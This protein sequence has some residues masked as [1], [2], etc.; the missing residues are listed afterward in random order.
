M[1]CPKCRTKLDT[2]IVHSTKTLH[3]VSEFDGKRHRKIKP[4]ILSREIRKI[5]NIEEAKETTRYCCPVCGVVLAHT[6]ED[7]VGLFKGDVS[8]DMT[9]RWAE[10]VFDEACENGRVE[11]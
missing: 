6:K 8:S 2:L 9:L 10:L 4:S 3:M 1:R 7:A 11:N 5:H